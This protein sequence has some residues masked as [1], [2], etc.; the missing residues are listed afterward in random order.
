MQ[1]LPKLTKK[2][3][4]FVMR[5]FLNG[6]NASEAY[7][8]AYD[9]DNMKSNTIWKEASQLLKHPNVTPWLTY[10]EANQAETIRTEI[11]YGIQEAISDAD[12]LLLMAIEGQGKYQEPNLTAASKFFELKNRL[13]GNF[14]KDNQQKSV[15]VNTMGS[16]LLDGQALD[17]NVGKQVEETQSQE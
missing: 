12:E 13:A 5:Y 6:K 9:T 14:E 3:E 11:K 17:L 7:R 4:K 2:Q 8:F 10:Y 15:Q 1:L 16:V